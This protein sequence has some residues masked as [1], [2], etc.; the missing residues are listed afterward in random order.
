MFTYLHSTHRFSNLSHSSSHCI[1]FCSCLM[2]TRLCAYATKRYN[3]GT[4]SLFAESDEEKVADVSQCKS[5]F[6]N[7]YVRLPVKINSLATTATQVSLRE[8][9]SQGEYHFIT[10]TFVIIHFSEPH[11]KQLC[12]IMQISARRFPS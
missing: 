9:Y 7:L 5:L 12:K 11:A 4:L 8:D 2:Q 1:V 3:F 10:Q 6:H